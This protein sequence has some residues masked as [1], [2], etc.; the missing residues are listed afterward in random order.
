MHIQVLE[1]GVFSFCIIFKCSLLLQF[2]QDTLDALFNILMENLDSDLYDNLVF[3]A[4][5][6]WLFCIVHSSSK[7][8]VNPLKAKGVNW[9]HFAIQV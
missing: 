8:C 4:L 7:S 5:V 2:L 3:D 9:L 1:W 6:G